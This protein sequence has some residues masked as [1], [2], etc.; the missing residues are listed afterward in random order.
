MTAIST[1]G[2]VGA[3]GR[4][5][6]A[7]AEFD[8]V[9]QQELIERVELAATAG[10]GGTIV[11]PNIDVCYRISKDPA[12][13]TLVAA[14]TLV[15]ADGMPLL[16]AARIAGRPLPERIT[17]A[18]LIY[19][20]SATAAGHSWPVYLLGGLPGAAGRPSVARLAADRLAAR[21]PG[22]VIAGAYAPPVK[23]DAEHGDI[24]SVRA[25]LLA[26]RP[27]IVFVG[28]GFPKQERLIARL[29]AD[30]PEAWFVGCGAAIPFAAGEL[31]R[32]PGWLQAVGLEWL[33]R[34]VSEPRRLA[35]R[36]L[37]RDLPFA[38]RLLAA[39]WWGRLRSG[40]PPS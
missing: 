13:R 29:T 21:Y 10:T 22:L 14:A 30:L 11:T 34:L 33:F 3:P 19:A 24:E 36:Y 37:G 38:L 18:D 31:S 26:T 27:K 15:V 25:E 9:T 40:Q 5:R 8:A 2:P 39:S 4:V 7:G 23:F 12:C 16:W 35:S 32:A 6:L 17:G 20:L 1:G 28:L